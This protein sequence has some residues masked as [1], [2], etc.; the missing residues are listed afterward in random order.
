MLRGVYIGGIWEEEPHK[1]KEE[2]LEGE[3]VA[4]E[5]EKCKSERRRGKCGGGG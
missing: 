2:I 4:M 5:K 1:V 3:C